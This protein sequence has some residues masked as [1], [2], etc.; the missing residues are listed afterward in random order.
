[1]PLSVLEALARGKIVIA[2]SIGGIPEIIQNG[3]NGLL[4]T[5]GDS[6]ELAEI[7]RNLGQL[8]LAEIERKA[9]ESVKDFNVISH[10]QEILKIYA[11]V[12]K[13]KI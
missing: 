5:S 8:N 6:E 9:K 4:F 7:I 11:K 3:H 10:T 2:S 13:N 1:M 12:L